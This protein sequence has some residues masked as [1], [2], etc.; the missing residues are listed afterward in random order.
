M[1]GDNIL[2]YLNFARKS[3]N[4]RDMDIVD[5]VKGY[6]N[7]SL[8]TDSQIK[9]NIDDFLDLDDAT[10]KALDANVIYD[11]FC[12][13]YN[14]M[15]KYYTYHFKRFRNRIAEIAK[16]TDK[17][18]TINRENIKNIEISEIDKVIIS[19]NL[20]DLKELLEDI[21][22]DRKEDGMKEAHEDLIGLINCIKDSAKSENISIEEFLRQNH[23][24]DKD[25]CLCPNC[26]VSKLLTITDDDIK[27]LGFSNVI[28]VLRYEHDMIREITDYH[29]NRLNDKLK[30][31]EALHVKTATTAKEPDYENM[32]KEE[33][34]KLVRAK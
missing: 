18:K 14:D 26:V 19:N 15:A 4:E 5:F 34:I 2:N 30:E 13:K 28:A 24:I 33:L 12:H 7:I 1:K 32:S 8:N 29:I 3:A 22:T 20:E 16:L 17:D 6:S 11:I 9:D 25:D 21:I 27:E 31:I 10:I 23:I